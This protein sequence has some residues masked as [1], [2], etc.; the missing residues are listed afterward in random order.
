[1]KIIRVIIAI[2][3]IFCVALTLGG[4]LKKID[5]TNNLDKESEY[6]GII[7]LWQIDCFEGG[8]G[9]RKQFL[10]KV[11]RD[12]EK[13]NQ[14]VLIMVI[15]HTTTSA[16]QAFSDGEY[17]DLISFGNG[18]DVKNLQKFVVDRAIPSGKIVDKTYATAWCRGGY[19][20]IKNP[21]AKDLLEDTIIVSQGEYTQPLVALMLEGIEFDKVQVY[22]PMDAYVKFTQGKITHFLGTQRDIVRLKNRGMQVES[23]PL[24]QFNDLYQYIALTATE[25]NKIV[26]AKR[27][28]DY[29]LSSKVQQSLNEI[30]ML[31]PFEIVEFDD[32]HLQKMQRYNQ[33]KTL[34][35]F[36]LSKKLK[37]IQ[38]LSLSAV[39]GDK[40]ALNKIKNVII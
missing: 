35:P 21:N 39:N 7:T 32:E 26:Y 30:C 23:T 15:N 19:V 24:T 18:L 6:K 31:S 40:N 17:P 27:F 3:L 1:M 29:L 37:E 8:K 2:F 5:Q 22:N 14:G 12:F 9:S 36:I 38:S 25:Q 4:G 28:I 33:F 16:E 10:L 11:A 34:S 13:K 20:L